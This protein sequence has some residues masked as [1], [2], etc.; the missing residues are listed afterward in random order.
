MD[1]TSVEAV[2]F[3]L[4]NTLLDREAL[5]QSV[6][7]TFYDEHLAARHSVTRDEAVELMVCWDEDGY[8]VRQAMR[9]R[10]W[11]SEWP[12]TGLDDESLA[13]WYGSAMDRLTRPDAEVNAF[14][15]Q[16]NEQ[17]M[18]WGIVTNGDTSRQRGK[19]RGAGLDRLA[20]FI[21]VSEEAGYEKPDPRIFRDALEAAGLTAPERVLF[22]G[23]N[24]TA[25][26]D[27]AKRFG[28]QAAWVR[29]GRDYPPDLLPPDHVIDRVTECG[30]SWGYSSCSIVARGAT[31]APGLGRRASH[32][33]GR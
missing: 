27:G 7:E 14:L 18:P 10:W 8:G 19:C 4:D 1:A 29:R 13:S 20:P 30:A 28:M 31:I 22:V 33:I 11:L 9:R 3:D 17:S 16:L 32:K 12:N 6:A 24:P 2:I 5:F 25:D 21:I 23:D 26:A 15:T